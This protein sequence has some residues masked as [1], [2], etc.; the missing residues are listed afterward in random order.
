ML[1]LCYKCFFCFDFQGAMR[2]GTMQTYVD[3]SA[4]E[5]SFRSKVPFYMTL[6]VVIVILNSAVF[7]SV[8]ASNILSRSI[9]VPTCIGYSGEVLLCRY[10]VQPRVFTYTVF[11]RTKL[12]KGF[13]FY[14]NH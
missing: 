4:M 10:Q 3:P 2:S 1:M 12:A 13:L 7:N 6:S 14:T 5:L 9:I 11:S 8:H